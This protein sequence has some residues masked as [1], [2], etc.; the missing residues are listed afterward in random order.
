M[1]LAALSFGEADVTLDEDGTEV[2]HLE[3]E[4]ESPI[5]RGG[6]W[7]NAKDYDWKAEDEAI[8]CKSKDCRDSA[9]KA[10]MLS[11]MRYAHFDTSL[12][13][14]AP[15]EQTRVL[16]DDATNEEDFTGSDP[17][18]GAIEDA[19]LRSVL[20]KDD[21]RIGFVFSKLST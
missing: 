8:Q 3:D 7:K 14:D 9:G 21:R 6:Q 11:L 2:L 1:T 10:K 4:D 5:F 12:V 18:E 15:K 19:I 20:R 13:D 16:D 17:L